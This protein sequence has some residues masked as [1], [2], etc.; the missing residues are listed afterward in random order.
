MRKTEAV[1][2]YVKAIPGVSVVAVTNRRSLAANLGQR[3]DLHCYLDLM[4]KGKI[5]PGFYEKFKRVA[6]CA[7]SLRKLPEQLLVKYDVLILDEAG[8]LRLHFGNSTME[9]CW[10][11]SLSVLKVLVK[12]AR[13]VFIMQHELTERDVSFYTSL[14]GWEPYDH[15]IQSFKFERNTPMPRNV[16]YTY[17][18]EEM[19]YCLNMYLEKHGKSKCVVVTVTSKNF[20]NKL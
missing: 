14:R 11:K 19:K 9:D 1:S 10:E 20:G 18:V 2:G 16:E 5:L 4:D 6:V 13:T 15:R 3:L 12:S 7:N 8:Y 17:S